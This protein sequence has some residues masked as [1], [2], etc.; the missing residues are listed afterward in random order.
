MTM[1]FEVV[2]YKEKKKAR[3][4]RTC[5]HKTE[6]AMFQA[7]GVLVR[8]SGETDPLLRLPRK[9][10]LSASRLV[11][12]MSEHLTRLIETEANPEALYDSVA[13]KAVLTASDIHK[14][15]T[16]AFSKS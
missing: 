4:R 10:G 1:A 2:W 13:T 8:M 9:Q 15:E 5:T 14:M 7:T 16:D 11:S 6:T 3:K 12:E